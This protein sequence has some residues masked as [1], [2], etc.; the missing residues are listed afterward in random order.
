MV[1]Y[2][3]TSRQI[4]KWSRPD[5]IANSQGQPRQYG[6]RNLETLTNYFSNNTSPLPRPSRPGALKLLLNVLKDPTRLHGLKRVVPRSQP[7]E[8]ADKTQEK[9]SN[10]LELEKS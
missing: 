9:R 6:A 4:L 2:E 7:K 8:E 10:L 3:N 5:S 1:Y